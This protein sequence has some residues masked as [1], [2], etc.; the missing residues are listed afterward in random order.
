MRRGL[1]EEQSASH[2]AEATRHTCGGGPSGGTHP[3]LRFG[4]AMLIRID[5]HTLVDHLCAHYR[6][7]GFH[8]ESVGGGMIEV[9]RPDAPDEAQERREV[10]MHLQVW[11][12]TTRDALAELL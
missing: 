2:A 3:H 5:N 11:K 6:R 7:S 8:A 4:T 1:P 9:A 10:L 12:V